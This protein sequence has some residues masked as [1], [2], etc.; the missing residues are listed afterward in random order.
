M[1]RIECTTRERKLNN[2]PMVF[3]TSSCG[4]SVSNHS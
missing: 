3:G 2:E 1:V 4:T